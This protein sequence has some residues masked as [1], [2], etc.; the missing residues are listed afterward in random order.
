[1]SR[2]EE[3]V[4]PRGHGAK[5]EGMPAHSPHAGSPAASEQGSGQGDSSS[6][7]QLW[8]RGRFVLG[9]YTPTSGGFIDICE[10]RVQ[11]R[12]AQPCVL[13]GARPELTHTPIRPGEPREDP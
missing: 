2:M 9:Q 13:Q 5:R 6:T 12:C 4:S 1:M 3:T 8:C 10:R 11:M 7:Y